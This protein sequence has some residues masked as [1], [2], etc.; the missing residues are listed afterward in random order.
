MI[1][2]SSN[3]KHQ[4]LKKSKEDKNAALESL[5]KVGNNIA[6][7]FDNLANHNVRVVRVHVYENVHNC[8][9]L[10]VTFEYVEALGSVVMVINQIKRGHL[11]ISFAVCVCGCVFS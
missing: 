8:A 2:C 3:C 5:I 10:C 6:A 11:T 7:V 4:T 1:F 9:L